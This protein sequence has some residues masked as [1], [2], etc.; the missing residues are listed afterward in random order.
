MFRIYESEDYK[1]MAI[2]EGS[3]ELVLKS[4][5]LADAERE[6]A[7]LIDDKSKGVRHLIDTPKTLTVLGYTTKVAWSLCGE[8]YAGLVTVN[9]VTAPFWG[10]SWEDFQRVMQDI[11]I[12]E[13]LP[14]N[15]SL[16]GRV[17]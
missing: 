6:V 7:S 2:I 3:P 15:L 5:S 14:E 16:G 8:C 17:Q 10:K 12:Q 1:W 11:I 4:E 13:I 9:G